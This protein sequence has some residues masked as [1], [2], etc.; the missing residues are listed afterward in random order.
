MSLPIEIVPTDEQQAIIAAARDTDDNLLISALAGAAKTS[1]LVLIAK[2]LPS[3]MTLCLAFNKRIAEEMKERLPGNC[4]SMTLNSLGHR[5]WG[6]ATGKRLRVDTKKNYTILSQLVNQLT[7][8]HDKTD[9]FESF[10]DTLKMIEQGKS[11]GYVPDNGN[12]NAK[13]L[14]GDEEFF[15]G[16]DEI[17][18]ELQERLVIEATNI[19]IAQGFDGLI[20]F[21]D[22]ILLPTIFP[23]S[24]PS[25]P[26]ILVDEAQ[27]LSALNHATLRKLVRKRLIAVGD[28][29]QA[30]Y[31]FRG[32]HEESMGLLQQQFDMRKLILSVS[33]RCPTTVVQ[34]ARWRAPHMKYPEWAKA[35]AVDRPD[36]WGIA[37]IPDDS[38]IICRNNAPIFT[39]AIKLL[40][41]GRYAEIIGNDVGR[42]L[43]KIMKKFGP[44]NMLKEQVLEQIQLWRVEKLKKSRNAARVEDQVECL[45]IFVEQG[46]NLGEAIAYAEFIMS[47]KG[48]IMMMTG[49]KSKGLEFNTVFILDKFLIRM[50]EGQDQNLLYV[51]QTRA[52]ERLV[53]VETER[54]VEV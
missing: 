26:L 36:Q 3:T 42:A 48:P 46:K 40:K 38:T 21:S 5:V 8:K 35:G 33:F 9:A 18:D 31:A 52:K 41:N 39:M 1:T 50:D 29:C 49:H 43:V 13:R 6:K 23:V 4:E 14:L 15:S 2:A 32:A 44:P 54:F 22:Q 16:L 51:M 11:A 34:E 37:D 20:D 53:Y 12:K 10:A 24:F 45:T 28:E 7:S 30:I 27:D 25:Y 19:S 17:P 47:A